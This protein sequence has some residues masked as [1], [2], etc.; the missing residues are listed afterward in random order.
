MFAS[1]MLSFQLYKW[2]ALEQDAI[3]LHRILL[4]ILPR[5][6]GHPSGVSPLGR[7]PRVPCRYLVLLASVSD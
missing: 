2:Q 1:F 3:N 5:D 4:Q 7:G 6:T